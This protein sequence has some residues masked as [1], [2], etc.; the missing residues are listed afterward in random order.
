MSEAQMRAQAIRRDPEYGSEEGAQSVA[1]KGQKPKAAAEAGTNKAAAKPAEA[2]ASAAAKP[3][4]S[5]ARPDGP[6]TET[7]RRARSIANLEKIA[8][9]LTSYT[10]RTGQFPPGGYPRDGELLYSWRVMILPDLGYEKLYKRFDLGE[11]WDHPKNVTLLDYI[12]P[13]YQS[14]ERFDNKTNYLGVAGTGMAI[15]SGS[16]ISRNAGVDLSA[17]GDGLDNTVA[18]VE[19]DDKYAVEWTRPDDHVPQLEAPTDRLGGLR[20]DGIFAILASGRVVL[21]ARD[22][23]ASKVAA[24]FTTNGGEPIGAASFLK[25]PSPEPP[26]PMVATLPDDPSVANQAP[27]EEG[28]PAASETNPAQPGEAAVAGPQ[29]PPRLPGF[30]PYAPNPAKEPLPD[31]EALAKARELLKE[32]YAEEYRQ[33]RTPEKQKEFLSKLKEEV[34]A[35]EGNPADYHELVRII[36]DLAA[37]MGDVP[38]ALAACD[39]LEQR[40][41]VDSLAMR[42]EVLETVNRNIKSLKSV[43][44]AL[45]EARRVAREAEEIDRYEIAVPSHEL[46]VSFARVDGGK[47]L[48]RLT[49]E[50]D[51]LLAS[52]GL[53][54]AAE[55]SL[56]KLQ[57]HGDDAAANQAVG[58]YLCLVKSRWAAGLPY[59]ARADDIRLRGIASLELHA[60][61]S[62]GET[63]S[64]AQQCWD[65]AAKFKHPQRRGL[66]LRAIY[67]YAL[68]KA[69]MAPG[70]ETVK[71][72]RRIDEA[73]A[74]YGR[75]EI[76]RILAPLGLTKVA[77]DEPND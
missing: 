64:L 22:L 14:P 18:V 8:A 45:K 39:L 6:L 53:F 7:E 42:L 21:L 51:S 19:V 74:L 16:L 58:E 4:V 28:A 40:F 11:R 41:Q 52:R 23:P 17:I 48:T 66:H 32:L 71:A 5:N 46:A 49:Q 73:A 68:V 75:E 76:D 27:G 72:Q 69:K 36:R 24:L 57:E 20:G 67:H 59:L 60:N 44:F 10:K 62:L 30:E 37:A 26:P 54:L 12:P 63:L 13:E 43:E 9:A 15:A 56:L 70:L 77:A 47:E 1:D 35:V 38:Q 31:E 61:R 29:G 50:T 25:A 33:A 2:T 34:A 65:L 3:T 55:R